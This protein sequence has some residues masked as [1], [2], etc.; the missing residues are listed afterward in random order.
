MIIGIDGGGTKTTCL[1]TDLCGSVRGRAVAGPSNSLKV[2]LEAAVDSLESAVAGALQSASIPPGRVKAVCAGLSGV[3]R[4]PDRGLFEQHLQQ[5][6]PAALLMLKSDALATLAGATAGRPGVIVISGTGSLAL[7][8]NRRG[9]RARCGGWGHL[10]GDEASGY[11]LVRKALS[12][13]LRALDGRGPATALSDLFCRRLKIENIGLAVAKLD[14]RNT[15]ASRLASY[16]PLV[17]SAARQGDSVAQK[18][19]QTAACQL[20]DMARTVAH[21]LDLDGTRDP[22]CGSGGVW[23]A[24]EILRQKFR[25]ALRQHYPDFSPSKPLHSP[26]YGAALIALGAVKGVPLF[27]MPEEEAD[28]AQRRKDAKTRR[29]GC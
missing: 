20:A 8:I 24:S 25:D 15:S 4:N 16:F 5:R 7:G 21:R 29:E 18:L 23:K 3:T 2:G 26:E 17:L 9:E 27:R 22:I 28:F 13:S 12:A 6:F 11:D 1:V 10:F 19:F 14:G